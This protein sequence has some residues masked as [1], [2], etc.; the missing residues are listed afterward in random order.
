MYTTPPKNRNATK[1]LYDVT[2][3]ITIFFFDKC[4][5]SGLWCLFL[6]LFIILIHL[7]RRYLIKSVVFMYLSVC[8]AESSWCWRKIL[9]KR[10]FYYYYVISMPINLK[11][12]W[13]VMYDVAINTP[14]VLFD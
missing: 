7:E 13:I 9:H 11:Q 1:N 5:S 3:N 14:N 4:Q 12:I 2:R 8:K 6:V 10:A